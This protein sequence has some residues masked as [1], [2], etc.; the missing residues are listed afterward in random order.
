MSEESPRPQP[1][2]PVPGSHRL[3]LN[4]VILLMKTCILASDRGSHES[5]VFY[6][7]RRSCPRGAGPGPRAG[8]CCAPAGPVGN[9]QFSLGSECGARS[10]GTCRQ[11]RQGVAGQ[12]L[13]WRGLQA[14]VQ[15]G[16][17]SCSPSRGLADLPSDS[18]ASLSW[19]EA[20]MPSWGLCV[21]GWEPPQWCPGK[22]GV[23]GARGLSVVS[24]V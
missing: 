15:C 11:Q 20:A 10:L 5:S 7:V 6:G 12:G 24:Q 21:G 23:R 19:E 4:E 3:S 8:R 16:V 18:R 1:L 14:G 2:N 17:W 9:P 22:R 13:G